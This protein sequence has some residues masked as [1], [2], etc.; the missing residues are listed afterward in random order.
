[1][2]VINL[3][4]PKSGT[5]TLAKALS[6][7]GMQVADHRVKTKEASADSGDRVFV[8]QLIYQGLYGCGDPLAELKEFDALS[9]ISFVH[10]K[11]SIWPQCDFALLFILQELYPDLKFIATRRPT[12][13]HVHSIMAWN[14]LGTQRLPRA[15]VPG[16]PVGFG[17]DPEDL[18]LWVDGHYAALAHWFR[19]SQRFLE[20]DISRDD[21]ASE[22]GSFLDL[23]LPW[24]GAANV[25]HAT[26]SKSDA[27]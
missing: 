23:D 27:P 15:S 1:M 8:A 19:G 16:M 24:W 26:R 13:A 7:A 17:T 18:M 4:L 22:L 25:N 2:K 6:R 11:A 14:N 12:E 3:G 9:E 21:A 5:T 20:L 10:N